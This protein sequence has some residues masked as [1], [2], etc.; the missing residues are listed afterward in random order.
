MSQPKDPKGSHQSPQQR[1][2]VPGSAQSGARPKPAPSGPTAP[3]A[4]NNIE[5]EI[6]QEQ[7]HYQHGGHTP[8]RGMP[9]SKASTRIAPQKGSGNNTLG[10]TAPHALD[11]ITPELADDEHIAT[12]SSPCPGCGWPLPHRL[13][14]CTKCGFVRGGRT[15]DGH[16]VGSVSTQFRRDERDVKLARD[17]RFDKYFDDHMNTP[18][19]RA[20]AFALLIG[21]VLANLAITAIDDGSSTAASYAARVPL[22]IAVA[23][24]LYAVATGLWLEFLGPWWMVPVRVGAALMGAQFVENIVLLAQPVFPFAWIFGLIL[25]FLA[26]IGFLASQLDLELPDAIGVAILLTIGRVMMWAVFFHEAT[27]GRGGV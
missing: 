23:T 12:G 10:P 25:G 17:D 16:E 26:L 8:V 22:M 24:G 21:C 5:L 7:D 2:A 15:S 19:A 9:E 13:R 4:L 11:S 27:G 18:R 3:P 20:I 1:A 14:T 6:R